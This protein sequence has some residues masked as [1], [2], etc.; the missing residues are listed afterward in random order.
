ME[1]CPNFSMLN[2]MDFGNITVE[3]KK[4]EVRDIISSFRPDRFPSECLGKIYERIDEEQD[5]GDESGWTISGD[6]EGTLMKWCV[7]DVD[8]WNLLNGLITASDRAALFRE[9]LR[10]RF[11]REVTAY[12]GINRRRAYERIAAEVNDISVTLRY[13]A[14]ATT[15]DLRQRLHGQAATAHVILD[16]LEQIC[17]RVEG[18]TSINRSRVRY[19]SSESATAVLATGASRNCEPRTSLYDTLI[20]HPPKG[21]PD[22]MLEAFE[23]INRKAPGV[24]GERTLGKRLE[25]FEHLLVINR[26]PEGYL[27]RLREIRRATATR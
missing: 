7:Y 11:R 14:D 16:G 8:C 13:L 25:T 5:P 10:R 24:L 27:T 4:V 21:S 23:I 9:K 18:L 1:K 22:F 17:A 2:D 15:I 6:L 26:A 3:R 12:D 20:R 19:T